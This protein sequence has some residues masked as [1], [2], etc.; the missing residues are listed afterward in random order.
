ME[1]IAVIYWSGTGNT[2]AMANAI[3]EGLK[4]AGADVTVT[5]V[6]SFSGNIKD[7]DKI[8]F[9]CSAM[10]DEVLEETE[11]EPFFMS[12][13]NNLS[14]KK[15]AIFGSYGWG[16]GQW[17]RDWEE[18]VNDKNANLYDTGFMINGM[19]DDSGIEECKSFGRGFASF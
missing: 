5:D 17:I 18:R 19:P 10:G 12:I 1:K 15:I 2:E 7:Y 11:F 6:S 3:G 4:E 9:G 14:G 8:A 16:D 13:E